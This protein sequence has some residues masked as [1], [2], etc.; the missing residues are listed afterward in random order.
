MVALGSGMVLIVKLLLDEGAQITSQTPYGISAFQL[1]ERNAQDDH[2]RLVYEYGWGAYGKSAS[3]SEDTDEV[4]LELLR[5][6]L[7]SRGEEV[8]VPRIPD[9]GTEQPLRPL[10]RAYRESIDHHSLIQILRL[11]AGKVQEWIKIL[12]SWLLKPTANITQESLSKRFEYITVVWF[13]GLLSVTKLLQ[14][15][16]KRFVTVGLR[17]FSRPVFL[18]PIMAWVIMMI[19][20]H[21]VTEL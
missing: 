13:V 15:S 8:P 19:W 4:M 12:L 14:P 20:R 16:A 2:P 17:Q 7:R 5:E 1:A 10:H 9:V 11:H 3:V 21:Y 18:A 6:T